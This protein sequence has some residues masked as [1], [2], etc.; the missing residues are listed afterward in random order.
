MMIMNT[1][2]LSVKEVILAHT[3]IQCPNC[4]GYGTKG[5]NHVKCPSCLGSGVLKVPVK[6]DDDH[7]KQQ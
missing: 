6:D 3:Y 1:N 2:T 4:S 5:F 7:E